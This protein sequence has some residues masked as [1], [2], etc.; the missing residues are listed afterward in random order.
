MNGPWGLAFD[1]QGSLYVSTAGDDSIRRYATNGVV[2]VV[3]DYFDNWLSKPKGIAF[4]S[5]GYLYVANSGNGT[6][7]K[8]APNG[9]S[10]VIASNLPAPTSIAIYPGLKLWRVPIRLANQTVLPSGAFQFSFATNP[11]GTNR[12]LATTNLDGGW[13]PIGTA[14]EV[15]PGDYQF[16]DTQATNNGQR[17]YR[18]RNE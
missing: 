3:S 15:S 16:T 2:E 7:M 11:Y 10:T 4:D 18:V 12:V 14:V 17:F 8:I 13:I 9:T 6:V 5:L 1:K